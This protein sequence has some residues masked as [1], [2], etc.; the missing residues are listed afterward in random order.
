MPGLANFRDFGGLPSG[1]GGTVRRG[2]LFRAAA[3]GHATPAE[4]EHLLGLDFAV[5]ADLRYAGERADEPSPWPADYADRLYSHDADAS[6][7]APHMA[8]LRTGTLDAATSD[9]LY[10]Q[11]YRSM[12]FDPFYGPLFARILKRLADTGGRALIHCSAGKDRTGMV[13]ALIL[14]ALGVPR[15]AIMADYM[16]SSR[17]PGLMAMAPPLVVGLRERNG[18]VITLE[19]AERLLDVQPTYLDAFFDEIAQRSGSPDQ[20]LDAIGID[21]VVRKRLRAHLLE[22]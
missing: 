2:R 8:P 11:I 12:P 13:A 10:E 21:D 15:E 14:H 1:L 9:R 19:L 7:E 17:D 6:H 18:S 5:I 20:Y 4:L 22:A 16:R 3:P